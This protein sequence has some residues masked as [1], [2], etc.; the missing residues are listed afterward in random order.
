MR[1]SPA[2][3]KLAATAPKPID[4][5]PAADTDDP[6]A[7]DLGRTVQALPLL[8]EATTQHSGTVAVKIEVLSVA[9]MAVALTLQHNRQFCSHRHR[10]LM[11]WRSM[12]PSRSSMLCITAF[13]RRLANAVAPN[14]CMTR[15]SR[16]SS[17]VWRLGDLE[18][19]TLIDNF[20]LALR[21][22][23]SPLQDPAAT[24]PCLRSAS[25][26]LAT[27]ATKSDAVRFAGN[28]IPA[29]AGTVS[30]LETRASAIRVRFRAR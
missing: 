25:H 8:T 13:R 30:S 22:M 10:R 4:A 19:T 24:T 2:N 26:M 29:A 5:L 1:Q 7:G 14:C 28:A 12:A 6:D 18:S 11:L 9:L 27:A 23:R 3:V 15:P 20:L 16:L 21:P 17:S